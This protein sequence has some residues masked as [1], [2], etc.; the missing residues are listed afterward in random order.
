MYFLL[1]FVAEFFHYRITF[2]FGNKTILKWFFFCSNLLATTSHV[3]QQHDSAF[4]KKKFIQIICNSW[5]CMTMFTRVFF[6]SMR[7]FKWIKLK[8]WKFKF[9]NRSS[10]KHTWK[11]WNFIGIFV[12]ILCMSICLISSVILMKRC[13]M[14][15]SASKRNNTNSINFLMQTSRI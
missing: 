13:E 4:A 2:Q 7:P 11:Y 3:R 15:V 8:L 5:K 10:I 1:I 14:T 9:L 6:D 12:E